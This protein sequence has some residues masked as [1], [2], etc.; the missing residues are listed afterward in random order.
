MT[1]DLGQVLAGRYRLTGA[2]GQGGMGAV[3]RAHD[4]RLARDVAVKE[5]RLP[6]HLTDGERANWVARL[7]REARAAA[8]LKHPGI[9]T[10]HDLI[11]DED[12]RPWIVMELVHGR[13]LDDLLRENGPLPL[14]QVVHIGLQ[15]LD[16]L[17][18]AHRAGITHRDIKPA[19]ILLERNRVVLT[20]FGIATL[21]GDAT[22]TASGL[23]IGTP[24]FMAPEQARGLPATA[25]SDLWSLGATLYTATEARPPFVGTNPG[26]VLVAVA[27]EEPA[28]AR[29]AG[30]LEPVLAGLLRK[31]PAERPTADRLHVLLTRLADALPPPAT[32]PERPA[33]SERH[34]PP[35]ADALPPPS[36]ARPDDAPPT[37]RRGRPGRLALTAAAVLALAVGAWTGGGALYDRGT[38]D[39]KAAVRK[40]DPAGSDAA[41]YPANLLAAREFGTPFGFARTSEAKGGDGRAVMTYASPDTCVNGCPDKV[42]IVVRWLREQ[43]GVAGVLAPSTPSFDGCTVMTTC[44]LDVTPARRPA[45]IDAR[46]YV[47]GTRPFLQVDVG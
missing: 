30:P 8:R 6:A 31:D 9:I 13:S 4:H 15:V 18:A 20:D 34:D 37:P 45:I 23:L 38:A 42:N 16:A 21:E 11:T 17:R 12:G 2:L 35:T 26:A 19:N 14:D 10:V 7:D 22:L 43:V 46:I 3:W 32:V 27:T 33:R 24:A 25:E 1:D 41:A 40:D 5:L 39:G 36:A 28:P 29:R 44:R 47:D